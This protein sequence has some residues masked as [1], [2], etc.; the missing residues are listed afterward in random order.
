MKLLKNIALC[1][2]KHAGK[3]STG[4]ALADLLAADFIDTDD[5]LRVSGSKQCGADLSVRDLYRRLGE[6]NFRRLEAETVRAEAR[7]TPPRVL[8]LGGGALSNPFLTP[9]DKAAL[10]VICFL[11][12][13]D[14][15]AFDRILR[16]GL[17]PFLQ[18]ESDPFAAFCAQNVKRRKVFENESH[19][20]LRP[21]G[22]SPE[23]TAHEILNLC[24][25][26]IL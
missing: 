20:R 9:E 3:T 8:A 16:D 14:R 21:D 22:K 4:R 25:E 19:I 23:E 10:G 6:E 5:A 17:P 11:D 26:D 7:K 13:N 1:G 15:T 2:I 12:V 24:R 18:G